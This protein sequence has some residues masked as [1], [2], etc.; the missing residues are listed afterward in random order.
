MGR[1]TVALDGVFETQG[2]LEEPLEV[3]WQRF[4][5]SRVLGV[6]L[7]AACLAGV[8]A[9]VQANPFA[10][11]SVSDRVSAKLGQ[12][13][14]CTEVGAAQIAGNHSTIYK[15]TVGVQKH[16][17]AQCFAVTGGEVAQVSGTRERG[18]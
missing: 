6:L 4:L 3:G 15:C 16:R 2:E 18:C 13:A 12:P 7:V 1:N 14:S 10:S 17:L 5:T 9:I 11:S 8:F